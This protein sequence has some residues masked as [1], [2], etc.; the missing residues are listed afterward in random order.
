VFVVKTPEKGGQNKGVVLPRMLGAGG[1]LPS[2]GSLSVGAC[3]ALEEDPI[4]HVLMV[5]KAIVNGAYQRK[6]EEMAQLPGIQLTVLVPPYWRDS[7]G[8]IPLQRA[9]TR[10]YRL[11]ETPMAWN[12]HFHLHYY[13]EL[14]HWLRTLQPDLLHMDEEPWNV[15]TFRGVWLAS[16]LG[17]PACFYTWQNLHRRY[18]PPFNWMERYTY[19]HAAHALA[20]NAEAMVI[21]R[22]KG[23]RGPVSVVPQF[24]VDPAVFAPRSLDPP[25]NTGR[26]MV[27]GYAGGLVP[28]KGLDLLLH[29]AA[30]LPNCRL[31]LA[32]DG[33]ARPDLVQLALDLGLGGRVEFLTRLPSTEMPQFYQSLDV[34][35][36]PSRTAPNWKEQFGRVLIEAM[37]CGVPV[38]GAAS[39]EIPQVIGQAGL[40]FPEGD[41]DALH[42]HLQ[43]LQQ[44]GDLWSELAACG[45]TRVQAEYTQAHVAAQT[46]AAYRAAV[47][48]NPAWSGRYGPLPLAR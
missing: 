42:A 7:R 29:A 19:H 5:S 46:V 11:I 6:L 9:Y 48:S 8:M 25:A 39:G 13:P 31:R 15:A 10:G 40:I 22:A 21:L 47:A 18:P 16:H 4:M 30:R 20:G 24:G 23:Y 38:V 37:A 32:G 3:E 36:L 45:R 26:T 17:I 43:R 41:A 35:V 12:G 44:D 34:L 27:I 28:E 1:F 14:G 33:R 2:G